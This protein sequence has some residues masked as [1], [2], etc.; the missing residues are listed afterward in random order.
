METTNFMILGFSVILGS[1]LLH[2]LSMVW[3]TRN[4]HKEIELLEELKQK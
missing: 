3:R 4:A 1:M 2:Y